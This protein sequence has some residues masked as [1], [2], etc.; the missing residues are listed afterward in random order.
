[1]KFEEDTGEIRVKICGL[2][3]LDDAR[4]ALDLGADFLG[5]VLYEKSPRNLSWSQLRHIR[6]KLPDDA[7]AVGVFVNAPRLEVLTIAEDC[8]LSAVQIH[9]SEPAEE[10]MNMPLPTWRSVFFRRGKPYPQ[11]ESWKADRYLIDV[12]TEGTFGTP[13]KTADWGSASYFSQK[14]PTMLAGGLNEHNI[15][16]AIEQVRPFGVDVASGVEHAPGK[17]DLKK[18]ASFIRLAK[19][20]TREFG[21]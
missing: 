19:G 20:C 17:K 6:E 10:F 2:T 3:I 4:A 8:G 12:K 15:I 18:M 11:P 21:E 5:F 16:R 7:R 1:M 13:G 9:G 14:W